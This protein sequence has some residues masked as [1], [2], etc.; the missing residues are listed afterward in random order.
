MWELA[1]IFLRLGTTAFGGPAAHLAMMEQEFVRRR[2]WVTES[3]FLDMIA[4]ANCIPGPSST[5]VAIFVG[6]RRAGLWGLVVAGCCF[7]LP[8]AILVGVIAWV[9]CS[10]TS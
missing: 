6:Y 4:V 7:I 3:E 10:S 5:E 9:T 2:G 1:G 8:A